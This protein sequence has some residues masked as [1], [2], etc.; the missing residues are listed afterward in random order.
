MASFIAAAYF[1]KALLASGIAAIIIGLIATTKNKERSILVFLAM[2]LGLFDLIFVLGELLF[3]HWNHF[4]REVMNMRIT[5]LPKTS[6]GWWSVGLCVV[7]I[8]FFALFTILLGSGPDY[9][10]P[11]AY[12]L[13][14]VLTG[15]S[16]AG[17]V[18]GLL[19]I[20][21]RKERSIIV[22]VA[23]AISLYSLISGLIGGATALLG[24]QK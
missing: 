5:I 13:T 10:M 20:M 24:L 8:L 14:A 21:K 9:N 22:F 18:T 11:L 2:L 4:S 7:S 23:M 12:A 17:F 6:L 16:V 3:L 19:G 15:I 1:N